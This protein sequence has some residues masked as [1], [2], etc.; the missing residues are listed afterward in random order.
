MISKK[1]INFQRF[2]IVKV[3]EFKYEIYAWEKNVFEIVIQ[4]DVDSRIFK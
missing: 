1:F 4:K 3:C 2:G